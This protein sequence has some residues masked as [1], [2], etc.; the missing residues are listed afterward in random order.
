MCENSSKWTIDR[1]DTLFIESSAW[2]D[3]IV[4]FSKRY[5]SAKSSISEDLAIIKKTF[6]ERGTG[7]LDTIPGAAGGVFVPEI[8]KKK[9]M[10]MLKG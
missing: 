1:Y 2:I 6:K 5:A 7:T 8:S 3:F 10:P 9:P 4:I